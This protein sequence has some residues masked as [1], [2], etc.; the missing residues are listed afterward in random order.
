MTTRIRKTDAGLPAF[1]TERQ[2]RELL[3]VSRAT[4]RRLRAAGR[5]ATFSIFG[6]GM[7]RYRRHE[8]EGLIQLDP[9]DTTNTRPLTVVR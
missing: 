8:I 1:V 6:T 2:A 7:R 3:Q 9:I 4:F 5:I